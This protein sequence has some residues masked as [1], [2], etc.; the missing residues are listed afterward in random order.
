LC[1]PGTIHG[2]KKTNIDAL[3]TGI[4]KV[5]INKNNA[6][7]KKIEKTSDKRNQEVKSLLSTRNTSGDHKGAISRTRNF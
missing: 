4:E 5:T 7:K 1:T 6:W 3:K 2:N